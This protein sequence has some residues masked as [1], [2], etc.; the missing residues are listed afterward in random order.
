MTA[1]FGKSK[2]LMQMQTWYGM[3][4]VIEIH[5]RFFHRAGFGKVLIPHPPA[6][7]WLLR[8]GMANDPYL[9]LSAIHEFGHLQI[10]P[11]IAV[12]TLG[13]VGWMFSAH[14]ES[15]VGV[16]ALLVGIHATWEILAELYVR[17]STGSLYSFYYKGLSV[18]PRTI[19]WSLAA[20]ISVGGW[21][22]ALR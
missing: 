3:T 14:K 13:V 6:V 15:V 19:F 7:N 16:I 9:K 10:L 21:M 22:M 17:L 20:A 2:N 8:F 12:Y 18:I 4:A 5:N 11:F 1:L